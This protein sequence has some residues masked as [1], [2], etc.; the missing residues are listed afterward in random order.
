[1]KAIYKK[2]L[3]LALFI[4]FNGLAQS[5][6]TGTVIDSKNK[7]PLAGV[8]VT[9]QGAATG[10][11]TDFDGSFTIKKIKTGDVIVFTLVGYSKSTRAY[12]GENTISIS[13][14]EIT[15]ELQEVVVQVGYGSVKKKD[16]TGSVG[17]ISA[18]DFNRGA[19][20]NVDGLLN[21][22]VS[23]VV[24]TASGTPGNE[25][26]IR[27]RGGSS[28][29][30]SNDP[31]LVVDGL[32]LDG[33]SLSSIN[34]N[35]IESLS[36][37]KDASA[38]AIYGNRGSNGVILVTTKKGSKK[39]L[40]VTLNTFTT[41][42][43]LA[44]KIDVFSADEYRNIIT[45]DAPSQ[46]PLLG[47]SKTDWQK[48]IFKNSFTSDVSVSILGNIF[49]VLPARLSIGNTDNHGILQ[50]SNFKR[51]TASISLNPT[52]LDNHLKFNI[53][54]NYSYIFNKKAD[55]SAIGNAISYDPT[56]SVYDPNSVFAG[57][58]E[59]VTTTGL[60]TG[61]SNPVS[62]L[63]EKNEVENNKRFFGNI[64]IDYKFHFL[65]ALRAILNAGV[66]LKEGNATISSNRFS[67]GGFQDVAALTTIADKQV[68]YGQEKWYNNKNKNF[69]GQLNYT[70]NFKNF[71]LDLLG[72]YEYQQFDE[73]KFESG[74]L[75]LYSIVP[76]EIN[77]AD[78]TTSPGNNLQAYFG[79]LN[80]GYNNKYLFTVNFRRDGSS[81][82]SPLNKWA[83]FSGFAFAWKMK[84]ESF[85][86]ESKIFSDLK[87]RLSYGE[88]G[89]Q[90][91]PDPYAWFKR[92]NTSGNLSYQFGNTFVLITKPVGYNE[93]LKWERSTKYNL[94]LDFGFIKNRLKGSIDGYFGKT[95]DLF[96]QTAQGALQNL[97]IYGPR[98]IGSLN[99][100]GIDF[101]LNY[102]AV[103]KDNFDLNFNYNFN[104][105][106][107]EITNLFTDGLTVG[108][109]G[110]GG[111][112]QT[113]KI[114]LSPN[115]YWVYEQVYGSNGKPIQGQ[116]VD[117]NGDGKI[118]SLDKYNYKKPQADYTMSLMANA[119]IY[120][121]WDFSMA[122]R[123]SFGN[124]VYDRVSADRA[125]LSSIVNT[126]SNTIGNSPI[127][128]E[129]TKFVSTTKESDYYIKNGTF[130]KLDNITIGYS[131]RKSFNDKMTL[132]FYTGIQNVLTITKYKNLDPEVFNDG[133]DG[134]IF[135]RAR[136]YMLGANVNF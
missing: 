89:Q 66:D 62:Q 26:T 47:K 5:T 77:N 123:A 73:E 100:K 120:K 44:K 34:P 106:N 58:T 29:L 133:I 37:L 108:G 102:Q 86:K 28:L 125:V 59:W 15:N 136:M 55:E 49:G 107:L 99:S 76:S 1:M 94:G 114:G 117:R 14:Q 6:L 2:L 93:N 17:I 96:A 67:R 118:D 112:V 61:T 95:N 31:L 20:T 38:T 103:Q 3:I 81:K 23:G 104:Y 42:N 74:N 91:L 110:L 10:T 19:I 48:E 87:L 126:V 83:N 127:D 64:N 128:Y 134:T 97:G 24:V 12:K 7:K 69:N 21:G 101:G 8:N 36:I 79:R 111:F 88:T 92:Y 90:N 75:N 16:A 119:T 54:G 41:F 56:Q 72:G 80:I 22:R 129:N 53:T 71:D 85:L 4:S 27:I 122:W 132:R 57:Y 130:L 84:E 65:P 70:K 131:I 13:L 9:L 98:N 135:P 51:T 43:T 35:D 113:Q 68:G 115:A 32:P 11:S 78:I 109:V 105:N 45:R 33:I 60:P 124:Y 39:G 46:L 30:A 25:S 121:N 116:F 50:T 63:L 82:I 18:K 40:Q 52:F